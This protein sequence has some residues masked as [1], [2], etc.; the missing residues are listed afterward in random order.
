MGHACEFET[1]LVRHLRP[2]LVKIE[3]AEAIYPDPGVG[4]PDDR[5]LGVISD[6]HL[7]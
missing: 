6:P 7:S 4:L 5:S 1:A 2:D 3:K